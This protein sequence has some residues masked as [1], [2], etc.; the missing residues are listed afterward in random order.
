MDTPT[1]A[2]YYKEHDPLKRKDL[3]EKSISLGEDLEN[4]EIRR[5]LWEIRYENKAESGT[6]ARADGFLALWMILEFNR[7]AGGKLFGAKGARKDVK[8]QLEKLRFHEF[9]TGDERHQE[10]L[11]RECCHLVKMYMELCESDKSYTS[12]LCGIMSMNAEKAKAKLQ[13][14]IHETAVLLPPVL[15]MEKELEILTKAAREM[16]ELHFPGEG[17]LALSE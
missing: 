4:N 1:I 15:G 16:Y 7:N 5:R 8:K 9:L 14:D 12:I 2:E 17:G 11:Y 3:L 6:D 10:L 13:K